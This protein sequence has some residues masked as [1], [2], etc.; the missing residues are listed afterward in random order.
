MQ[1]NIHYTVQYT[2]FSAIY[3]VQY[4]DQPASI[5]GH[6]KYYYSRAH[7]YF[8]YT[9]FCNMV[10]LIIDLKCCHTIKRVI[11]SYLVVYGFLSSHLVGVQG[12]LNKTIS[13]VVPQFTL[14]DPI[15]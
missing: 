5:K 13:L 14:C 6:T 7:I 12:P 15:T 8:F 2:V 4:N 1:Y 3:S 11:H 10:L 9:S